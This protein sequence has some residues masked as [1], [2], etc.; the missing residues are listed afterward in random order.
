MKPG[1]V[2]EFFRRLAAERPN[3]RGELEYL[4]P[5]TLLVAVVLSAQATDVGV[6]KATPA[7]FAA[8]DTPAKMVALGEARV[9]EFIRTIGLYRT[10][11]KNVIRLS[12]MLI[13]EHGGE[14]AADAGRAAD[15]AGGRAQDRERG[16]QHR[17][18]RAHHRRRHA[19]LPGRQP[20]RPGA[21]QD[22]GRGG[23]A[24]GEG[25]ARPLQ[26]PRPSL[27]D[28]ARPLRLRG[29]EAQVHELRGSGSL[30]LQRE[31]DAGG[32]AGE[33]EA[34]AKPPARRAK[35]KPVRKKKR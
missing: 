34:R 10:K 26:A 8:A 2:E 11:A 31:D 7:L 30:R 4:S 27:A 19:Y 3:P 12:E 17:L 33:T 1:N 6:N 9:Q 18:R 24:P 15:A 22:A 21:G 29:A 32:R 20:H 14:G 13:A 5:Y 28:P 25:G 16:A 23:G 35:A